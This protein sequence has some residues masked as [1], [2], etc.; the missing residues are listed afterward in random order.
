LGVPKRLWNGVPGWLKR[1]E[2]LFLYQ[3]KFDSDNVRLT[4]KRKEK[5]KGVKGGIGF[6]SRKFVEEV[7]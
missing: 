7:F 2:S 3:R 6:V 4:Q 1:L 5:N